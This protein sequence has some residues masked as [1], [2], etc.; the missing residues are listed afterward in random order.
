M[1]ENKQNRNQGYCSLQ[2]YDHTRDFNLSLACVTNNDTNA[3]AVIKSPY[4]SPSFTERTGIVPF[5]QQLFQG[6]DNTVE[7]DVWGSDSDAL[8]RKLMDAQLQHG[9]TVFQ[10]RTFNKTPVL[11]MKENVKPYNQIE[12]SWFA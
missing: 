3:C 12:A 7:K 9:W 5:R 8:R 6:I 11:W 4:C 1:T 10:R 2:N